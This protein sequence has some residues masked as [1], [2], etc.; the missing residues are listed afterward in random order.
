MH[1]S[2]QNGLAIWQLHQT[3]TIIKSRDV[4]TLPFDLCIC[5][6]MTASSFWIHFDF[7]LPTTC[8]CHEMPSHLQT[9]YKSLQDKNAWLRT[10]LLLTVP[11]PHNCH[12]AVNISHLRGCITT[13][14]FSTSMACKKTILSPDL[15]KFPQYPEDKILTCQLKKLA[16]F[17]R[18]QQSLSGR[19]MELQTQLSRRHKQ[20]NTVQHKN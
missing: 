18:K 6:Q 3:P 1:S 7:C 13:G 2:S 17:F 10:K 16:A 4:T 12:R 11:N 20:Y 14:L 15:C 5:Q 9:K 8:N 19:M